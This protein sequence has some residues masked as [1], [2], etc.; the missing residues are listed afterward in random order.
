M[1][2]V[3]QQDRKNQSRVIAPL[4]TLPA[5][6]AVVAMHP[7]EPLWPTRVVGDRRCK[8][9]RVRIDCHSNA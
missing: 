7:L 8:D 5:D 4:E 3:R 1:R 2:T 9:A 6:M